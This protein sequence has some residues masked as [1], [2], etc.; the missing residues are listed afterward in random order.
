MESCS[1]NTKLVP[2]PPPRIQLGPRPHPAHMATART[3]QLQLLVESYDREDRDNSM[4]SRTWCQALSAQKSPSLPSLAH[5]SFTLSWFLL[6]VLPLK[7]T[8]AGAQMHPG[9]GDPTAAGSYCASHHKQGHAAL[10]DMGAAG[11]FPAHC[12]LG[13]ALVVHDEEK[14]QSFLASSVSPL[15][16]HKF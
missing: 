15:S 6:P 2:H 10:R 4:K 13:V 14:R 16:H 3:Y 12:P 1:C 7:T 5:D 9:P 8:W 11:A